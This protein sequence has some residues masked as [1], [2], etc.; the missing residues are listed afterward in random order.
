VRAEADHAPGRCSQH[1]GVAGVVG[2]AN[3]GTHAERRNRRQQRDDRAHHGA[4][5][6]GSNAHCAATRH[7][8]HSGL[9][10]R[11]T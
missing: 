4:G 1:D 6:L 2:D 8:Q 11:Q 9:R 3:L 5:V 7:C 10:A